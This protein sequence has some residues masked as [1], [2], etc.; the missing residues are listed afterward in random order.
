MQLLDSFEDRRNVYLLTPFYS[1]GELFDRIVER[2]AFTEMD[3]KRC[4]LDL[5]SALHHCHSKQ[6]VHR[7]VKPEN[8]LF[9]SQTDDLVL[10]DFGMS[11]EFKNPK[12]D[13]FL[14]LQCG[15][16]SY[17][18]PEVLSRRYNEKCDLWSVGVIL[19]ILLVGYT[20]FGHGS[21]D[22]IMRKVEKFNGVDMDREEWSKISM[23][24]KSLVE[25]LLQVDHWTR[26]DARQAL[27][28]PWML[29]VR[30]DHIHTPP[31]PAVLLKTLENIKEFNR[32][33][34]LKKA[35]IRVIAEI[36][37]DSEDANTFGDLLSKLPRDD[38][39]YV[40]LTD[41]ASILPKG[42]DL[43]QYDMQVTK[44][45]YVDIEEIIDSALEA[46]VYLDDRYLMEAFQRFDYKGDGR[47]DKNELANALGKDLKLD[48]DMDIVMEAMRHADKDGSGYISFEEFAS[49][50]R[51][52]GSSNARIKKRERT[53]KRRLD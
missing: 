52:S 10:V 48:M 2:G 27:D 42:T 24:G 30:E 19:H 47:L 32:S 31:V 34:R 28:H 38:R 49:F 41:L 51:E 21:D 9:N 44:S 7:D 15:S 39:G 5:L 11:R 36:V 37:R 25:A 50:M 35:T 45:G 3:A 8:L 14:D 46:S 6:I 1:G 18:A 13:K 43:N 53:I 12:Q 22:Q 4:M 29:N 20:P 33:R 23:E 17:V 40:K 16:P 26:L